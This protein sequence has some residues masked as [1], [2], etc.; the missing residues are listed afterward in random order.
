M[1]TF[2][3]RRQPDRVDSSRHVMIDRK[4]G[5]MITCV[6]DQHIHSLELSMGPL[7]KLFNRFWV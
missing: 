5:D 4:V 2:I 6:V 7:P 3:H 1:G